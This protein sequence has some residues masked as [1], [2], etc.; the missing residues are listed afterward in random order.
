MAQG[1]GGSPV[2]TRRWGAVA[3]KREQLLA[4]GATALAFALLFAKP[5]SL[6]V[7]D[8]WNLP[9]AGHGLL[10]APVAIWLCWRSG[11][12]E[13]AKPDMVLGLAMLC[14]AGGGCPV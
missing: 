3:L 12:R 4:L 10:L 5:F 13:N 2:P 7:R 8:W 6:L 11:V 14:L 1:S 9:E